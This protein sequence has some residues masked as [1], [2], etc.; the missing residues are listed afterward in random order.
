MEATRISGD[1]IPAKQWNTMKTHQSLLL[2][3]EFAFPIIKRGVRAID[4][5]P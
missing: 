1:A 3:F 2:I 4:N 5:Y